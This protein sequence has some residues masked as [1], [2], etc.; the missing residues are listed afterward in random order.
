MGQFVPWSQVDRSGMRGS[1]SG[2]ERVARWGVG[3]EESCLVIGRRE[4]WAPVRG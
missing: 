2:R 3:E 4:F 1:N